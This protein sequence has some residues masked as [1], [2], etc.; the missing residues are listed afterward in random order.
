MVVW[1][2]LIILKTM[3][4]FY[5]LLIQTNFD[6]LVNHFLLPIYTLPIIFTEPDDWELCIGRT[7]SSIESD[8]LIYFN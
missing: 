4:H 7:S 1:F 6:N 2:I 3:D 5:H 8:F